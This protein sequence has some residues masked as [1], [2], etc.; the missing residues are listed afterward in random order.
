MGF[1]RRTSREVVERMWQWTHFRRLECELTDE[2]H[3]GVEDLQNLLRHWTWAA[4][5]GNMQKASMR[6]FKAH[7]WYLI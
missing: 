6:N 5:K 2:K 7:S 3:P 1:G 4:G